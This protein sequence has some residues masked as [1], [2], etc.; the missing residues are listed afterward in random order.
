MSSTAMG[1]ARPDSRCATPSQLPTA[2]PLRSMYHSGRIALTWLDSTFLRI[3][4]M[5]C[6]GRIEPLPMRQI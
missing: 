1:S 4:E 3:C 6:L 2:R 5:A